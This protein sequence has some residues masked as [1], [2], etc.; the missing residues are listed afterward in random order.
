MDGELHGK[1]GASAP[2][3]TR[4]AP[5]LCLLFPFPFNPH[6]QWRKTVSLESSLRLLADIRTVV[7]VPGRVDTALAEK[8]GAGSEADAG[9]QAGAPWGCGAPGRGLALLGSSVATRLAV[10]SGRG[11]TSSDGRVAW[12]PAAW[13]PARRR[14]GLARSAACWR[15]PR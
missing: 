5:A 15:A 12:F 7:E 2:P 1:L 10:G 3:W 4:P 13:F 6:T 9:R 8:V 11:V 14:T